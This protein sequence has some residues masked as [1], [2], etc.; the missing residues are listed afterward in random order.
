MHSTIVTMKK[1]YVAHIFLFIFLILFLCGVR[2]LFESTEIRYAEATREMVAS[3]NWL[4]PRLNGEPHLTK[5]PFAYWMIGAGQKLFY[6]SGLIGRHLPKLFY[7]CRYYDLNA[8][9]SRLFLSVAFL[10]TCYMV[11]YCGSLLKN[12]NYGL[13]SMLV[14]ASSLFPI[15]SST[16]LSTDIFLTFLSFASLAFFISY[17]KNGKGRDLI[18]FYLLL[19]L[20]F[21]TKGPP[22][23]LIILP[24]SLLYAVLFPDPRKTRWMLHLTGISLA[25]LISGF[26][27]VYLH[28][29]G[30]KPFSYYYQHEFKER[31]LSTVHNRTMHWSIYFGLFIFGCLPWHFWFRLSRK[32][33]FKQPLTFWMMG[34]ITVPVIVFC[35]SQSR[36]PL[37]ILPLFPVFCLLI[38]HLFLESLP[39][40]KALRIASVVFLLFVF[41][42]SGYSMFC[43]SG[44]D[45]RPLCLALKNMAAEFPHLTVVSVK[46]DLPSAMFYLEM[47]RPIPKVFWNYS[48][49]E[50]KLKD[51]QDRQHTALIFKVEIEKILKRFPEADN[52]RIY[53]QDKEFT[54]L[55]P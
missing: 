41:G 16:V 27:F 24:S 3:N 34:T 46:R 49:R 38:T 43:P 31:I 20:S 23:L 15:L 44:K 52:Y 22:A 26:W 2:S 21:L 54:I 5:P 50:P 17:R 39:L 18:L 28:I 13:I 1:R 37:Y 10:L 55:I 47:D 51:L 12:R 7:S 36:L 14:F 29:S 25:L 33:R 6:Q 48:E 8:F 53:Y 45:Q 19:G 11:L 40:K 30:I 4:V 35:F 32:T 9:S 42:Y